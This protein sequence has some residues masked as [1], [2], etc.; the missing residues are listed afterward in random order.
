MRILHVVSSLPTRERPF[1]K[2]FVQSQIESLKRNGVEVDVINIRGNERALNYFLGIFKVR[3][4]VSRIKYAAVHAHYSFCGWCS[5]FQRRSPVVLS[6][7]GSDLYGSINGRGRQTLEGFLSMFTT[8]VLI[9]IVNTVI[10]KSKRMKKE[11]ENVRV[12]V[13]PNGIDF[14]M[15]KPIFYGMSAKKSTNA[16][17]RML[18]LGNPEDPRKNFPLANA[19]FEIVKAEMKMAELLVPF[20]VCQEDVVRYMNTCDVLLLTSIHEGSPNVI[21]EAMACNLP[22]VA[23]DVGDVRE[24]IGDTEGCYIASFSP[25]DVAAKIRLALQYGKRTRGRQKIGH[26][27]IDNVART[28]ISI[29]TE[30]Q[31]GVCKEVEH[32]LSVGTVFDDIRK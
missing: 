1:D 32:K 10:V 12:H 31:Y 13:V 21:K 4:Q 7:M 24:V 17:R 15:F 11:I 22:I 19:A 2:P 20:G 26:L 5:I 18:F 25:Q 3:R 27:D 9:R 16:A 30:I 29:Y 28:I 8:R 23:T 6:L 14:R